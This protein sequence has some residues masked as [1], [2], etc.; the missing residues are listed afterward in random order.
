MIGKDTATL[1]QK[2]VLFPFTA[3]NEEK[4]K[5]M[6]ESYTIQKNVNVHLEKEIEELKELLKL[7]HTLTEY[8]PINAMVLSRNRSYWFQNITVD[9]GKKDGVG[10]DMIVITSDGLIGKVSKT[11]YLSSEISLIT[12]N[13]VN[14]KISVSI[15]G[16][17]GESFAILNGYEQKKGL[18]KLTGVDKTAALEIG[19]TVTTSGLGGMY[20]RGIYIGKIEKIQEDKYGLSKTVYVKSK[21]DFNQIHYVTILKEK[22]K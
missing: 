13:D 8:T 7:N 14:Y 2:V 22:E 11:S 1:I 5:T 3:L 21:Q 19:D 12:M 9:K 10:K 15:A 17:K 18:L 20:P 4:G 6:T 16:N